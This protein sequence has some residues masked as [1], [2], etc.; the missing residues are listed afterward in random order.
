MAESGLV[1]PQRLLAL[2]AEAIPW[3]ASS[4]PADASPQQQSRLLVDWLVDK[5]VVSRFQSD[6]LVS[7]LIAGQAAKFSY[8]GYQLVDQLSGNTDQADCRS[9]SYR[10]IHQQ[11][12]FPAK[13]QF[14]GGREASDLIRW[15]QVETTCGELAKIDHPNLLACFETVVIRQHRFVAFEAPSGKSLAEL[16]P[17]KGRLPVDRVGDLLSQLAS[18]VQTLHQQNIVHGDIKSDSVRLCSANQ[19][20]L[21]LRCETD[22]VTS[23]D[24]VSSLGRLAFRILT[25][26][27]VE[28]LPGGERVKMEKYKSPWLSD[29]IMSM[30]ASERCPDIDSIVSTLAENGFAQA[31]AVRP[32]DPR[33]QAYRRAIS[34]V[35]SIGG[36]SNVVAP[37]IETDQQGSQSQLVDS[38]EIDTGDVVRPDAPIVDAKQR[39]EN[40]RLNIAKRKRRR[41]VQ[42]AM[43]ASSFSLLGLTAAVLFFYADRITLPGIDGQTSVANSKAGA[44]DVSKKIVPEL[45]TATVG[46]GGAGGKALTLVQQIIVPDDGETIWESPTVG[47]PIDFDYLPPAPKIVLHLRPKSLLANVEGQQLLRAF[48]AELV[49]VADQFQQLVGLPLNETDQALVSFHQSDQ[50]DV[51]QWLAS[52]RTTGKTIEE[53]KV[54]WGNPAQREALTGEQ[55]WVSDSGY[56]YFVVPENAGGDAA[57]DTVEGAPVTSV[58]FLV[59]RRE[60]LESVIAMGGGFPVSGAL[61]TLQSRSDQQMH[62][63]L[64]FLRPSLFNDF[65]KNWM[66]ARWADFNRALSVVLPNEVRGGMVGL[67]VDDGGG[68]YVE[69]V[70]ERSVDIKSAQLL[71]R[72]KKDI[73]TRSQELVSLADRIPANEHWDQVRTRYQSMLAGVSKN[74]RWGEEG[75]EVVGNL[76]LPPAGAH[77][78]VAASEL[79]A[80]FRGTALVAGGKDVNVPQNLAELLAV[81]RDLDIA[82]PPD[83]NVLMSDLQTELESDYGQLPFKWRIVLVGGDLEKEGITKNQRPGALVIQQQSL[84]EILTSIVVSANPDKDISGA[85]DPNC[86]MV[87]VQTADPQLPDQQAILITTR[88][89][90]KANGYTLPAAFEVK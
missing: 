47:S 32:A 61:Q 77:N 68:T 1:L 26:R 87:W 74:L 60:L 21:E 56:A 34:E 39:I 66:G 51:Y 88:V 62:V 90:A 57:S 58:R 3:L 82:N 69:A 52:V 46:G 29:L 14:F 41:W 48:G 79:L 13:L 81:K 67:Q 63:S 31:D 45:E 4:L 11:T 76:W 44:S 23:A 72:I 30:L 37:A 17:P 7:S 49:E 20:K 25:G 55:F 12:G 5:N 24:D 10:A 15:Q 42:P 22:A 33:Q 19:V 50:A 70:L 73:E 84:A 6:L 83:L 38:V 59:G 80:T 53:L 71:A 78:L 35:I 8:G 89:A 64:M 54:A 18:A 65:G 75:G 43:I 28:E 86:K 36:T 9:A 2:Q 40:A 16:L 27:D 85:S